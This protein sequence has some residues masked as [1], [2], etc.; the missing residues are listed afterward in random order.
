MTFGEWTALGCEFWKLEP[1]LFVISIV[2][3]LLFMK[4]DIYAPSSLVIFVPP[5]PPPPPL[6]V[7]SNICPLPVS[8]LSHPSP[9][10]MFVIYGK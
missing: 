6:V 1:P 7:S 8:H 9:P 10:S 2:C 3:P 5:P 4:C